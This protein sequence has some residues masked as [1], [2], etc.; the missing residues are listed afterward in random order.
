MG[1]TTQIAFA[2]LYDANDGY[3]ESSIKVSGKKARV[4]DKA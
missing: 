4:I 1:I 2:A 3:P